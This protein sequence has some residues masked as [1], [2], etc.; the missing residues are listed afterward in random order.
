MADLLLKPLDNGGVLCF[1][2]MSSLGE[3][4]QA[5]AA[6]NGKRL[7]GKMMWVKYA[8]PKPPRDTGRRDGAGFHGE[9]QERG[10]P[11]GQRGR[12]GFGDRPEGL[13]RFE[14][15]RGNDRSNEGRSND[16]GD[17]GDRADRGDRGDRGSRFGQDRQGDG[18]N[19]RGGNRNFEKRE[20]DRSSRMFERSGHGD[21]NR[22]G[23]ASMSEEMDY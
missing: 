19:F 10:Q 16:R 4:E 11:F 21:S 15:G 3:A 9:R 13:K 20:E 18:G 22:G 6:L 5:I 8:R 12:G 2:E 23:K 1:V 17:R 7:C 14:A